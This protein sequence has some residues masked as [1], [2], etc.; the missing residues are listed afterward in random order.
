MRVDHATHL[1]VGLI[2]DLPERSGNN[3]NRIRL[4]DRRWADTQK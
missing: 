3:R 2:G 4:H 1:R